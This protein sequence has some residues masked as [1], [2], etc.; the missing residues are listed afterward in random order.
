MQFPE[1][2]LAGV[3][4]FVEFVADVVF[5]EFATAEAVPAGASINSNT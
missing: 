4:L 2:T 1:G 3:V 5:V